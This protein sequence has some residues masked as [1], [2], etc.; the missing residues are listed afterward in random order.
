MPAAPVTS[1]QKHITEPFLS[2]LSSATRENSTD[3]PNYYA[4]DPKTLITSSKVHSFTTGTGSAIFRSL[5]PL[6]ES[7]NHELILVTCFWAQSESLQTLNKVL[8]TLS[9]KAIHRGTEKIRVRLCFSS[10]SLFQKLFHKQSVAGQTYDQ[11]TWAKKLGLPS[12]DSLGGLDLQIKSVFILPFSVMHPKFI[13]IDRERAVLPSCNISWEEWFEG[14]VTL[15]GPI[16]EQFLHFYS[17][18][19]VRHKLPPLSSSRLLPT[20]GVMVEDHTGTLN[21]D[22]GHI[23]TIPTVFLPS[24]HR[25]NPR[26]NPF[27][28][29]DSIIAPSTPLN[30]FILTLLKKANRSIRIQSPNVTSPPVLSALLNALSRGVDVTI[31]TSERLMILEQLVTAGTTTTRCVKKLI[32]RYHKL[33]TPTS[34]SIVDEEAAIATRPRGSLKISYFSPP[35]GPKSRGQ[36]QGEPQQSHLKLMIVDEEVVVLGSGNLD[37]AS[38]FTSQE[39]G[40]AFFDAGLVQKISGSLD[41]AMANRA[42]LHYDSRVG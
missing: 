29:T 6:L 9:E 32:K 18:F 40:V 21:H 38:W 28:A 39:L 19:W 1:P 4:Q 35:Q 20:N 23:T 31:L 17:S 12:P 10:L 3:D 7:T 27:A 13:I 34:Q 33:P 25:R 22:H 42:K 24:P 15:S 11:S 5:I 36:E 41:V 37:R 26:L 16:I 8:R 30:L 2:E 14:A